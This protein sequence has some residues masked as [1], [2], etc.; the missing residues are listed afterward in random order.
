MDEET[1]LGPEVNRLYW[2]TE[3]SVAEISGRLGISRRGLYEMIEPFAA[4]AQCERC[5]GELYY[6]NRS[7][8]AA[9]V[10]RCPNCGMERELDEDV[11]HEDVGMI[12][13]YEPH[14]E[15]SGMRDRAVAIGGYALAGVVVGAIATL[16]VRRTR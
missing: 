6:A 3:E 11:S 14:T 13:Q 2:D 1:A 9:G 10:A 12:P 4:G 8:K 5:G 7:A 16:I 15:R